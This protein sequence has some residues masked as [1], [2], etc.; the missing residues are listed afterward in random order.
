MALSLIPYPNFNG[1]TADAMHFYQSVFGGELVM[2]TFA[3]AGFTD[4]E[5]WKDKIV[6]AQLVTEYFTLMASDT[7]PGKPSM[8]GNN[9]YLSL[10]GEDAEVLT[11]FFSKLADGGTIEMPLEKQFW[12]DTFGSLT[13]QFGIGW[14]INISGEQLS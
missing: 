2:Q 1:R 13:D 10:V 11:D 4:P 8:V 3:E 9:L 6:H 12:G 14:M 5:E 7:P